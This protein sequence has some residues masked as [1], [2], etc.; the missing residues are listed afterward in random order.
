MAWE[1][2]NILILIFGTGIK[3]I[4]AQFHFFLIL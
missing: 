2:G 1:N 4:I 3:V